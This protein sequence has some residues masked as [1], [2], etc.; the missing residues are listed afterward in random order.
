MNFHLDP[1]VLAAMTQEARECF[2]E[3][4]A[5]E[6]LVTLE[7][8]LANRND[9][10]DIKSL[11]RAAHSIKGGAGL[12]Q[13]PGL[14][15]LAH[16]LEDLLDAFQQ[17]KV[18]DLDCAWQLLERGV[19]DVSFLLSRARTFPDV[20][21]DENLLKDLDFFNQT[22]AISSETQGDNNDS[23]N[24]VRNALKN[25]LEAYFVTVEEL[26]PDLPFEIILECVDNFGN[27][28]LFLGETLDVPWLIEEIEEFQNSLSAIEPEHLLKFALETI[29]K[30][31]K[32][33]E[34]FLE[35]APILPFQDRDLSVP[36]LA[37]QA[38][39][40]PV[41]S[42]LRIP[43]RK[44]EEIGHMVE[45]LLLTQERL[46][47]QQQQ[48]ERANIRLRSLTHQFEPIRDS[49]QAFYDR[50]AIDSNK[51]NSNFIRDVLTLTNSRLE[52]NSLNG[53]FDSLELDTFTDLHTNLQTFQELMLLVQETR[54]DLDLVNREISEDLEEA[55]KSL[56]RLYGNVTK[57]RLVNFRILAQRFFPQIEHLNRTYN[58][59]VRLE[60]HG[61]E[62]LVNQVLL[63][64]LQTPLTHLINNAF[65]HGIESE[66][67]RLAAN[68]SAHASIILQ[69]EIQNNYLKISSIDDGRG[70][71]L[72]K[73]YQRALER[74]WCSPNTSFA[75][76]SQ[77]QILDWIFQPSFSTA[78]IVSQLSGRGLGLDIVKRQVQK[79][80][81]TIAVDTQFGR[82]TKFTLKL[83]LSLSLLSLF[84]FQWQEKVLAIPTS[85][86]LE[87][88]L[89]SELDWLERSKPTILWHDREIPVLSLANLLPYSTGSTDSNNPK[90]AIVLE[91]SNGPIA[92]LIDGVINERQLIVKP[93]DDTVVV[94]PYVGGCTILGTGEVIPVILPYAFDLNNSQLEFPPQ[95]SVLD[96]EKKSATI[97]LVDDS[98]TT[99]KML[100]RLLVEMGY[101]VIVGRDGQEALDEL[102]QGREQIDLIVSD[103]E[104]PRLNGFELLAKVRSNPSWRNLPVVM[105]TSRTG[106]R[107]KQQADRLGVNGYLGKPVQPQELYST[108][109]SLLNN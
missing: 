87:T 65:D 73:V 74:G 90:V 18:T 72:E 40:M 27:D 29:A 11:F 12:A 108:V 41:L 82:G 16:K 42:H 69:A 61:E 96:K 62:L 91:G 97:L 81:G 44:V 43:L 98:V 24:V 3:E 7:Q 95:K 25:D 2:L 77:E 84:L 76:L 38:E 51:I 48:L 66:G 107:H 32:H 5:P 14:K 94:P 68:K 53:Q 71:N 10:I 67:E 39:E 8:G 31:R 55:K 4:D 79:L 64:Q 28:C 92:T 19:K 101:R 57:S 104:M 13:L 105:V 21:A 47:I 58:K 6:Y 63:E 37:P 33:R 78:D 100:E 102:I 50:T 36:L 59:S 60:I 49:V 56:E 83:P 75:E 34:H 85:N 20:P 35:P 23:Q 106:D 103:V 15:E 17:G 22:L 46:Q 89:Y 54:T 9:K 52:G 1:S 70:I 99:R 86:V 88:L 109:Q 80:R 26:T 30:L 45:E 93:F